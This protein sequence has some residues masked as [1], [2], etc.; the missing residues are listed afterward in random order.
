MDFKNLYSKLNC[1]SQVMFFNKPVSAEK[2]DEFQRENGLNLPDSYVGLLKYFD[3]GELF[4]PGT[5][6]YGIVEETNGN[7]LKGI[8]GKQNRKNFS[9]PPTYLIIGKINYGDWLCIDLNQANEV[10]QWDHELDEEFCRWSSLEN[11]ME[12]TI[13]YY[14]EYEDGVQS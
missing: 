13:G 12:E 1:F 4:I 10:I 6:I 9:I 3:G 11:W 14:I 2:I 8:N 5:V 7:T